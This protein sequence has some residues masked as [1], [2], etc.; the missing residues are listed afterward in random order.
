MARDDIYQQ[1]QSEV[2]RFRFDDE[3]AEVFSDMIERSVPGYVS[4]LKHIGTLASAYVHEHSNC[5]DLGCSLGASTLA[6]AQNVPHDNVQIIGI[7]NAEAMLKRCDLILD[8]H[9][10]N[11]PITLRCENIQDSEIE[12]ASMVVM[13]FTLQFIPLNDRQSLIQRIYD[14]MLDGGI[15]VISEKFKLDDHDANNFMIDMHHA[16]KR[17]NGYSDLEISQ[18]RNAIEDVLI[19]ETIET[20]RQ[21]LTETGFQHVEQWFQCFNFM[22]MVARK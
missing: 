19:P 12:R 18:K 22:S 7:D 13:N 14:G 20:H 1:A 10:S 9:A 11:C 2:A 3:V 17:A 21:R 4:T 6:M 16:F 5:Y 15:L 8:K